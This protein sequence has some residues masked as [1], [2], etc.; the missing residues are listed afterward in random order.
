MSRCGTAGAPPRSPRGSN[1]SMRRGTWRP[2]GRSTCSRVARPGITTISR[3]APAYAY[4]AIRERLDA[5]G[6]ELLVVGGGIA[7]P[8][9]EDALAAY[10]QTWARDR[11]TGSWRIDVLREPWEG[12]VWVCAGAI[13]GYVFP[14]RAS[15]LERATG[16][17]TRNP[18]S[19][20]SSRRNPPAR[21]TKRTSRAPAASRCRPP[22][23]A[24]G[25][26]TLLHPGRP[27][28]VALAAR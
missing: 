9:T 18:R 19:S 10:H 21:R 7:Q 5:L 2:A 1:V 4:E 26:L 16:F 24:R 11:E 25:C 28:L 14:Q 17:H 8:A 20:S 27:W 22:S 12:D 23:L 3:S 13:H 15:L 6:L